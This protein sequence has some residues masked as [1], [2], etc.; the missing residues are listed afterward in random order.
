MDRVALPST[1]NGAI[2]HAEIRRGRIGHPVFPGMQRLQTRL[3]EV[4]VLQIIEVL[5]DG[6]AYEIGLGAPGALGELLEPLFQI[7]RQADGQ[8]GGLPVHFDM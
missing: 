8:H 2:A 7:F 3:G 4:E 6:L 1:C 5:D